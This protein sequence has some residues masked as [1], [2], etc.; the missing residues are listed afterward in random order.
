MWYR[1]DK[2]NGPFRN[3]PEEREGAV[4]GSAQRI[5]SVIVAGRGTFD[6]YTDLDD[7]SLW[8]R[9]SV[10]A[11]EYPVCCSPP[12]ELF[13]DARTSH[14]SLS[15]GP[16][17]DLKHAAPQLD[18]TPSALRQRLSRTGSAHVDLGVAI[19]RKVGS[20][21]RVCFKRVS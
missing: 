6:L 12:E 7:D 19:A 9:K 11:P 5:G 18:T 2:L 4:P 21:W 1:Y 16:W 20:H 17:L 13:P 3:W 8:A 10:K 15:G 14:E